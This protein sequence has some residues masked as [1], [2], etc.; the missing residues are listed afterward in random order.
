M[1]VILRRR[2]QLSRRNFG[3]RITPLKTPIAIRVVEPEMLDNLPATDPRAIASRRDLQRLNLWLGNRRIISD[4][5]DASLWATDSPHLV[6]IGCGDATFAT[7]VI[8]KISPGKITLLDRQTT[9]QSQTLERF[10][11]IG[12]EAEFVEADI[13]RW[14]PAQQKVDCIYTNLFLHH[15]SAEQLRELFSIIAQRT[16]LFIACEPRRSMQALI[17]SY[18]LTYATCTAVTRYDAPVSVRAG[19]RGRELSELWPAG[20]WSL[21]EEPRSIASHMFKAVK[22]W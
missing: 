16:N 20:E 14:P 9:I 13:F 7:R 11:K 4:A 18:L 3:S 22:K 15:F 21:F 1:D 8:R 17:G 2:I 10:E 19:F 6:E 12:W 5:L